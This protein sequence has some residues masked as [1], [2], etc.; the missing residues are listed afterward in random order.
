MAEP[1]GAAITKGAFRRP[2]LETMPH[3]CQGRAVFPTHARILRVARTR[4]FDKRPSLCSDMLGSGRRDG[5]PQILFNGQGRV[6]WHAQPDFP[7]NLP[8]G[9]RQRVHSP[10]ATAV[11]EVIEQVVRY[12]E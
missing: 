8:T 11:V 1:A 3:R 9:H 2:T 6:S 10:R 4:G 12:E 7:T 5:Q